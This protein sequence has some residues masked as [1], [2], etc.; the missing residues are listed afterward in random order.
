MSNTQEFFKRIPIGVDIFEVAWVPSGTFL[1][2]KSENKML[3]PTD[4]MFYRIV[5]INGVDDESLEFACNYA[6]NKIIKY[7]NNLP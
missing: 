5:F 6:I 1:L 4:G 3:I 7:I 2:Q